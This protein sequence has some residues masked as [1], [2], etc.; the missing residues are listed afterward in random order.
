MLYTQSIKFGKL[1]YKYPTIF[2]S[3]VLSTYVKWLHKK[4][5]RIADN[6]ST[7]FTNLYN[8]IYW[9]KS[10]WQGYK[11]A[12]AVLPL[13]NSFTNLLKKMHKCVYSLP[14]L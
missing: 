3:M 4:T 14:W 11:N 8:A 12:T 13:S 10:D 5:I 2:S 7:F 6:I 1:S 9:H